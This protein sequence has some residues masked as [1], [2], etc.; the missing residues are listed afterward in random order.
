MGVCISVIVGPILL[1]PKYQS[2]LS[3]VPYLSIGFIFSSYASL[4]GLLLEKKYKLNIRLVSMIFGAVINFLLIYI[5]ID[6]LGILGLAVSTM[7]GYFVVFLINYAYA[8][9]EY[10]Y[11]LIS[12]ELIFSISIITVFITLYKD[13]WYLNLFFL[14]LSVLILSLMFNQFKKLLHIQNDDF[15]NIS[16][17]ND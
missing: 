15:F 17:K 12:K 11:F 13:V 3:I 16:E 2:A 5:T 4:Y 14:V 7:V 1:P 8:E 10:K 6:G 9:K